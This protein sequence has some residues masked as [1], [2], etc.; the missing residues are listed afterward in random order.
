[1]DYS[2]FK[3]RWID[4]KELWEKADRVREEYWPD[5]K[6]PINTEKIVEFGLRLDIE[7]IHNLL[8]TI[9]I[10][11]YLKM[12]LTGIVVDYDCYM[13][14]KF[15]NRMRFSFAHELGHLFLHR[16]IYTKLDV[17]SSEEWKNFIL[18]VPEN[19][20][21]SFEWQANE[22][23]GRLL[24]PHLHLAVEVNKA[25]E[26]IRENNL[27]TFLKTDSDA[28]LSGIS[29]MLCRPFGVST[30]VIEIRVKREGLWPPSEVLENG[31]INES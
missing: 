19:E 13:N 30:D 6:L 1:M 12:D 17:T 21:R 25:N 31:F 27:I 4:S 3:C 18:N 29:P 10:D 5:N 7:P 11:A 16:D 23:A 28:V 20:Y 22:F 2:E 8:S 15:A 26:V 9:D 24:V 14:E